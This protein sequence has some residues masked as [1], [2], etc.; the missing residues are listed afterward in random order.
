MSRLACGLAAALGLLAL[1]AAPGPAAAQGATGC[2]ALPARIPMPREARPEYLEEPNWR[3]RVADVS[4]LV[5]ADAGR[6]QIVFLGDSITQ[7][8]FP[9]VWEQFYGHR[10]ALNLGVAGDFTQGLLWRIQP[11]GQWPANLRPKL[12][13]LLIGTNNA[14]F[15]QQPEDTALGIAEIIRVIRQKSPSTKVLLVGLLPRGADASDP[16]R[17]MNQRVNELIARCADNQSVFFTDP[18]SMLVD[19]QGRLSDQVAFDRLHLSYVGY[20]IL[21]AGLEPSIRYLLAR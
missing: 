11:G 4:R 19:G 10:A 12:A 6:A 1:A 20:A 17:R 13:V 2:A 7:G 14:G 3:A 9:Q 8:W 15:A 5:A 21:A 16:L 18:G